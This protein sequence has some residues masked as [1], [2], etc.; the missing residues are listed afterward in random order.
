MQQKKT[1]GSQ[2]S[3]HSGNRNKIYLFGCCR[4][5]RNIMPQALPSPKRAY[6]TPRGG[7]LFLDDDRLMM[8]GECDGGFARL[9]G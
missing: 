7:L 2:P 5:N 1:A 4:A 3:R 6:L 9:D 8:I